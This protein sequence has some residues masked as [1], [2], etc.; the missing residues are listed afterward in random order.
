MTE[1]HA[2]NSYSFGRSNFH[3][4]Q[5]NSPI[6]DHIGFVQ[7]DDDGRNADL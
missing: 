6:V 1:S 3:L 2:G 7:P 4:N 5:F